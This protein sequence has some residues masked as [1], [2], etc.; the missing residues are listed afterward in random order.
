M[1]D[2][3]SLKY[4]LN[5]K[6]NTAIQHK[7]M[8][9]LLGLDYEMQYKKG[10]ENQ[11]ANALS[12]SH[13]TETKTSLNSCQAIS[14]VKPGWIAELQKSCETNSYYED[15]ITQLLLDPNSHTEYT[16][17]DGILKYRGK[18]YVGDANNIR[19]QLIKALHA[20]TVG[21]HSG[22][23]NCWQK[24]KALFYQLGMKQEVISFIQNCDICQRDKFENIPYARLLQPIPVPKQAQFHIS[25]DFIEKLPKSYGYDTILVVID[26]LTNFGLI[27]MLSHPFT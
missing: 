13:E 12:R 15:L 9:K 4:L 5:Q 25:M 14:S 23:R 3:Q 8:T 21:D 11:V 17:I 1:T 2:H 24:I 7:W 16:L 6:L 18:I 10:A 27:I 22:Q 19:N 20:S 26:S